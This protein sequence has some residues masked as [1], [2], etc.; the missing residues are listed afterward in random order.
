LKYKIHAG[1][2]TDVQAQHTNDRLQL[3]CGTSCILVHQQH[4]CDIPS[5]YQLRNSPPEQITRKS[6]K[7][8]EGRTNK[9]LPMPKYEQNNM[10]VS[11]RQTS[12]DTSVKT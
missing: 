3:E 7:Q 2:F 10:P 1:K 8:K 9:T 11:Y 4:G 12:N 5:E 6:A